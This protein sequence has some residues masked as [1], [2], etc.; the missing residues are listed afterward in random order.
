MFRAALVRSARAALLRRARPVLPRHRARAT[1]RCRCSPTTA[2][3]T[4]WAIAAVLLPDLLPAIVLGPLLGALVD[5]IGWRTCAV[6]ADVLRCLAFVVVMLRRLAAGD[7]RRRAAW[8]GSAP[9]CSRPPRWPALPR[10]V[11]RRRRT[12]GRG[13]GLFGAIDDIGLTAGPGARRASAL[14]VVSPATLM[15]VNAVTFAHL[16]GAD[17]DRCARAAASP[18]RAAARPHAVRGRA[19]GRPRARRAA[20]RSARC[21]HPRPASCSASASP[22][23]A[24][25]SSRARSS[26]VGGSGLAAD[27]RRRR[28]RHRAR[29]AVHPLHHRRLVGLAPRLRDRPRR[30]MVVE[31]FACAVLH[32]FWL[33]VPALALGGF[34][35]GLA[36]VHDRLLLSRSTPASLARPPVRP[37]EDLRL[38]RLRRSPSCAPA[39]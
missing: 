2:S 6:V 35:N 36:L 15:G 26:H 8:P 23:S 19:R 11:G 5:R 14:A 29:L 13:M 12:R 17:R 10:L 18:P 20:P 1:S 37:A 16:G 4:P 30:A 3:S 27:G 38:V 7:D 9:R 33:V 34:G 39:P 31:L 21:S 24:R 28:P 25:S 32:S 22:T